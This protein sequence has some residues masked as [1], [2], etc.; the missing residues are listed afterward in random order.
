MYF[1]AQFE[2]KINLMKRTFLSA[3]A[4]FTL[5]FLL[6]GMSSL[7]HAQQTIIPFDTAHWEYLDAKT[8]E[9]Q[10]KSCIMGTAILKNQDITEGVIEMDMA[11][12]GQR[13]YPGVIFRMSTPQDY[14]RIYI[15]PHLT[16]VFQNVVQYVAAFNDIDSWQ[17]YS[18]N[19]YTASA[20]IPKNTWFHL[21][22]E[23]K[24]KQARFYLNNQ[25]I[26]VLSV[27]QLAHGAGKGK[28]GVY[29]PSDGTAYFANFSCREDKSLVFPPE[30]N[31][32][33]PYGVI[34]NWQ[35]SPVY[36]AALTDYEKTPEAQGII[37]IPWK[38]ISCR[39]DGIVDISRIYP[40]SGNAPD[41]IFAKTTIDALKDEDKLFAFGYSDIISVFLN[42]RLLFEGN[43]SYTSRDPNFQGIVGLN[44]YITLPLK[45]GKN[46]LMV[47]VMESFGGW[48]FIFRDTRAVYTDKQL[49]K[50]WELKNKFSYPESVAYDKKRD[51][52]YV[53]NYYNE[54]KEY[55]S[56][57]STSGEIIKTDWVAGIMQPTGMSIIGDKLFVV[58]RYALVEVDIDKGTVVN[59]YPFPEPGMPNDV[60]ADDKGDLYI[61][62]SQKNLI[63]KC[64]GGKME[65]WIKSDQL[66][67]PNGILAD[68]G[69]LLVG[70]S[71]DGC[72]KMIDP[73]TKEISTKV[74]IG[75]GSVMDGIA[76]EGNGNYLIS[77]YN[78]RVFRVN[79]GGGKTLLL[80]TTAPGKYC[81]AFEYIPE[82]KLLIIPTFLDNSIMTY[83]VNLKP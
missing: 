31:I 76:A 60:T 61:T 25:E 15:R 7:T 43:S 53:S 48:G 77:D 4:C 18:G 82:K 58:G 13:S 75:Q 33:I 41:I 34:E 39:P 81:A 20:E 59:R 28:V 40:R 72:I 22:L 62:D 44:D 37:K 69:K 19:G 74:C 79:M 50:K 3:I 26:P 24:G 46:E 29:G 65:V 83:E 70:T 49:V 2:F 68:K 16:T 5:L 23:F 1:K 64:S 57:V 73:S 42:G 71:G 38:S 47:A 67:R 55:I 35:I 11:V 32:E 8:A 45:K 17:L 21:K 66:I 54:G 30:E 51:V 27:S 63:Y 10:G 6:T 36:K 80:N 52:L 56:K 12:T 9:F 78:G 14:E